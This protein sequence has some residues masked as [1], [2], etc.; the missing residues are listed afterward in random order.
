LARFWFI[1]F[2]S[3]KQIVMENN[4]KTKIAAAIISGLAVGAATWYFMSTEGGK[5]QWNTLVD[6]AKD[7]SDKIKDTAK[8]QSSK[9]AEKAAEVSS[10]LA[11]RASEV[12]SKYANQA[13]DASAQLADAA[14][15]QV[16]SVS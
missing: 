10:K 9:L 3:I 1:N 14:K 15:K 4:T 8:E 11:D 6:V 16:E 2:K 13:I 7:F 5:Q 12:S